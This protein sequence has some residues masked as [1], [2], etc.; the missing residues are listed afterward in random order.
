MIDINKKFFSKIDRE[1]ESKHVELDLYGEQA[2]K[3][4]ASIY[5]RYASKW[6]GHDV[7][8]LTPRMGEAKREKRIEQIKKLI[9]IVS[10]LGVLPDIYIETQFDGQMPFLET[11]GLVAVPFAN[12]I[13]V[14]AIK[15]F[16]DSK[17]GKAHTSSA[18]HIDVRKI[19]E[20]S[21]DEMCNRL[22]VLLRF[23]KL[24]EQ[25]AIKEAEVMVRSGAIDKI[26]IHTSP[27]A[28]CGK[29]QY[30]DEVWMEADKQLN[31]FEKKEAVRIKNEF[32][33]TIED[34]RIAKYV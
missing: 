14:K 13:S 1:E 20:D 27:L 9:T 10:D 12:L 30:L 32:L 28:L 21:S 6:S 4:V 33:K 23:D 8:F 22:R 2:C 34:V 17:A 25:A 31:D 29:S 3:R 24:D 5:S 16:K 11:R 26:Y 19:I 18:L 7:Y 15:R